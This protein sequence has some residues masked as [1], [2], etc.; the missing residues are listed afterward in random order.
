MNDTSFIDTSVSGFMDHIP[1]SAATTFVH[2]KPICSQ[3]FN[4]L[5]EAERFGKKWLLKGLKPAYREQLIYQELLHKELDI[6]MSLSYP[7]IA[8]AYGWEQIPQLGPCI[9]MDYV[10]G[11]TLH[12]ALTQDL[13]DKEKFYIV[14]QLLET[15]QYIHSKQVVHR[16][17]KPS[18]ILITHNGKNVKL[19]DFGLS[20]T[21]AYAILKQPAGTLRYMSPEQMNSNL[22]DVRNDIY[23]LGMILQDMQLGRLYRSI[24]KR[25]LQPAELRYQNVSQLIDAVHFARQVHNCYVKTFLSVVLVAFL[26]YMFWQ[27]NDLKDQRLENLQQF[28]HNVRQD[29]VAET[30]AVHDVTDSLVQVGVQ[31]IEELIRTSHIVE[32]MDSL[33]HIQFLDNEHYTNV[34][35]RSNLMMAKFKKEV[36]LKYDDSTSFATYNRLAYYLSYKYFSEWSTKIQRLAYQEAKYEMQQVSSDN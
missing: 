27:I 6:L 24:I 30:D 25:C 20:D 1:L 10:E 32:H 23:S 3:G 2:I 18:N 11:M 5:Y 35:Y 31:S 28:T 34:I 15:V 4:Q 21:D 17:L 36:A 19:I 12:E 14:D 33:S 8:Q 7:Y 9:I 13:T 29:S 26:G 22:P 16:D